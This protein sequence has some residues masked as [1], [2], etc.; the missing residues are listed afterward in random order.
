MCN[1]FV[2]SFRF[3]SIA[4]ECILHSSVIQSNDCIFNYHNTQSLVYHS[5]HLRN[6]NHKQ[7]EIVVNKNKQ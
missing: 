6:N 1:L 3:V 7:I 5:L 4:V 2:R